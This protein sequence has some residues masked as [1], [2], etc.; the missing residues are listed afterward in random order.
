MWE[1]RSGESGHALLS[2]PSPHCLSW[3]LKVGESP[4][5][6]KR[7]LSCL[8]EN[9]FAIGLTRQP[10]VGLISFVYTTQEKRLCSWK[11]LSGKFQHLGWK[12]KH[13]I[14]TK[15]GCVWFDSILRSSLVSGAGPVNCSRRCLCLQK[16]ESVWYQL[17]LDGLRVC[18]PKISKITCFLF[19]FE[20]GPILYLLVLTSTGKGSPWLT[21]VTFYSS[22]R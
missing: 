7:N 3:D 11:S 13:Y 14:N 20:L 10:R 1:E 5:Q 4:P 6:F 17:F 18:A 19:T 16:A 8:A 15:L 2:T 21:Y 9:I 12:K 22:L